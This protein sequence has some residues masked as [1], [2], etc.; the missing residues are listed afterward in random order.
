M[1]ELAG[2]SSERPGNLPKVAEL[3]SR[4][5]LG[6]ACLLATRKGACPPALSPHPC[7]WPG[8]GRESLCAHQ[9]LLLGS[10]FLQVCLLGQ[11]V[12]RTV[13]LQ[14]PGL[15]QLLRPGQR[16]GVRQGTVYSSLTQ[17]ALHTDQGPAAPGRGN[18]EGTWTG[19]DTPRGPGQAGDV[20]V[21]LTNEGRQTMHL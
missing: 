18:P 19:R 8:I 15:Q 3:V 13:G 14:V 2:G 17:P 16:V 7:S 20:L 1:L 5:L 4:S 11:R 21:K 9:A 6:A 10:F 12:R